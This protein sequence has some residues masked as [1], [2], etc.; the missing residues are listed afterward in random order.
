MSANERTGCNMVRFG[1][2]TEAPRAERPAWKRKLVQRVYANDRRT[3]FFPSSIA[4][5]PIAGSSIADGV[6]ETINGACPRMRNAFPT[7]MQHS[8]PTQKVRDVAGRGQ[9]QRWKDIG[10]SWAVE[11]QGPWWC[12]TNNR[13]DCIGNARQFRN[14]LHVDRRNTPNGFVTGPI[15]IDGR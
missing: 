7:K 13:C 3:I 6:I 9:R 14:K 12:Q 11:R 1:K 2:D 5:G 8:V 4:S 15:R 10:R